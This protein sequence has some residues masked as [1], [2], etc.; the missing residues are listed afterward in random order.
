[1]N[2]N[3]RARATCFPIFFGLFLFLSCALVVLTGAAGIRGSAQAFAASKVIVRG[4][5]P[6]TAQAAAANYRGRAGGEGLNQHA[7]IMVRIVNLRHCHAKGSRERRRAPWQ[8]R[9]R[10]PFSLPSRLAFPGE[11][12]A[13]PTCYP[14]AVCFL[15]VCVHGGN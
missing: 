13:P 4:L 6:I 7:F 5:R 11:H 8:L 9:D 10:V 1:M 14:P 12:P 3:C 2:M 15:C